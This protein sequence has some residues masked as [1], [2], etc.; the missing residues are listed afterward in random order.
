RKG[1]PLVN[2]DAVNGTG[3][4]IG[5]NYAN[6]KQGNLLSTG[7]KTD[8]AIDGRGYFALME[9]DGT[10]SYTRDGNFKVD[11]NGTLVTANGT[12]V[13][14]DY[15]NGFS[16]GNPA[17]ESENL[18]IDQ[19]G[20]ISMRI[21]EENVEIG[22]IPVFTAI[23]DKGFIPKGNNTFIASD[24]AQVTQSND[25]DIRQGFLEASNVDVSEVFS[26]LILT[27]K[28]FQLSSKAITAADDMW[29]MINNMR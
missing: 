27:Q 5:T 16:E 20:M 14:V 19:S 23:G 21:G 26:D 9:S 18:S 10:V 4:R 25:Y 11:I 29:S 22:S 28:A 17:L 13:Y 24:D 1:T 15:T 3:V 12:K 2:K 8:L 7:L 6:N